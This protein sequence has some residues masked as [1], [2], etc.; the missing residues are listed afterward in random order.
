MNKNGKILNK[1]KSSPLDTAT[2]E[3]V[4]ITDEVKFAYQADL[5]E[6]N[7]VNPIKV[8]K[9]KWDIS[10]Q[11]Q[12]ILNERR[13]TTSNTQKRNNRN[14]MTPEVWAPDS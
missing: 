13:S 5:G 14:M 3:E 11:Q 8:D 1:G 7:L 6:K 9:S 4:D 2:K 12:E 10:Q